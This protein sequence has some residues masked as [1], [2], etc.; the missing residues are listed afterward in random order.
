VN[1]PRLYQPVR[2]R[3]DIP[4]AGLPRGTSGR[5]VDLN[6]ADPLHVE[7]EFH[8]EDGSRFGRY[9]ERIVLVSILDLEDPTG[10]RA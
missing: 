9:V 4:D 6:P 5:V 8:L 1:S 10:Q 2:L 3:S 7:V